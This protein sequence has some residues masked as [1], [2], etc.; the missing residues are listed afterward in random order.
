MNPKDKV[1][2]KS[3]NREGE[4]LEKLKSGLYRVIVGTM[5]IDRPEKD[6]K[7]LDSK[8]WDKY[9]KIIKP[10]VTL[11]ND[12]V[13][14][15]QAAAPL[16]LH[17]LRVEEALRLL[18]QKLDEAILADVDRVEIVHGLGTGALLAAV[19]TFLKK[20]PTVK[21]FKLLE[22]NPGTTIVYF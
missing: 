19:H 10:K 17:G 5:Q 18:S 4:I 3:L 2:V 1:F 15:K 16:D 6:L 9:Q 21:H 11:A 20:Q 12:P 7:A 22:N 8:A 14:Q 13:S